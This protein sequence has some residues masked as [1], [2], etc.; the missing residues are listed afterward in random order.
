LGKNPKKVKTYSDSAQI[1]LRYF[2]TPKPQE[3]PIKKKAA[4]KIRYDIIVN[5]GEVYPE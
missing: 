5:I 2:V 3:I 1:Q 4:M